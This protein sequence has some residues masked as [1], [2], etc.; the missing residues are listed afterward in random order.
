MVWSQVRTVEKFTADWNRVL[1]A[2]QGYWY[3]GP[4]GIIGFDPKIEKND[5]IGFFNAA[6]GWGNISQIRKNGKQ[7]NC[8]EVNYGRLYLDKLQVTL[9]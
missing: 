2:V 5:I 8:I 6:E 9:P 7:T 4:K 3:D 1:Q